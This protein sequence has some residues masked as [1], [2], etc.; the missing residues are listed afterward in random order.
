MAKEDHG[1]KVVFVN[2]FCK[3]ELCISREFWNL[4]CKSEHGYDIVIDEYKKNSH[5]INEALAE[6]KD[7]YLPNL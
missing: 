3:E 6:I 2:F 7:A 1:L 5:Y 4:V